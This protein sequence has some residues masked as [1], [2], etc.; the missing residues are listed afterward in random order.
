MDF[1][2]YIISLHTGRVS[3]PCTGEGHMDKSIA[4]PYLSDQ[5]CSTVFLYDTQVWRKQKCHSPVQEVYPM[6]SQVYPNC[7]RQHPT[8]LERG[9]KKSQKQKKRTSSILRFMPLDAKQGTLDRIKGTI[10]ADIVFW[11]LGNNTGGTVIFPP[12]HRQQEGCFVVSIL[13]DNRIVNEQCH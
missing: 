10:Q 6:N 9:E 1:F 12:C 11:S 13:R 4:E 3:I 5:R 8:D 2:P 7:F